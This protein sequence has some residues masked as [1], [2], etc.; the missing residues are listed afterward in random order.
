[1]RSS[2]VFSRR[3]FERDFP[4]LQS[5]ASHQG[6]RLSVLLVLDE[7]Y[8]IELREYQLC[9]LGLQI[10]APSGPYLI[11]FHTIQS[12]QVTPKKTNTQ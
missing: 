5:L 12:I 4:R 8:R 11:P 6:Q 1:M 9:S 2:P 7:G 10:E 3:Y